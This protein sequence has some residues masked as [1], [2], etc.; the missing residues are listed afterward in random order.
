MVGAVHRH[1][2]RQPDQEAGRAGHLPDVGVPALHRAGQADRRHR[3]DPRPRAIKRYSNPLP[4][5]LILT[6]IV[7]G[8]ATTGAGRWRCVVRI[9]EAYGTIEEDD[10]LAQ[11]RGCRT[12]PRSDRR[13]PPGAAG[14]RAAGRRAADRA[15]ASRRG[16]RL[17][18]RHAGERGRVRHRDRAVRSRS[19]TRR[20]S[21]TRIGS[22]PP[23]WG[24]E[25]R[26]DALVGFVLVLVSGIGALVDALRARAA[27]PRDPGPAGLPVLRDVLPVPDR[28]A[29][30]RHHRRRCSTSSSSSRSRRSRPTC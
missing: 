6:A 19:P 10:I 21:P 14:R 24:I 9:R 12:S 5:V 28:A 27:S 20:R 23:P 1:R 13:A 29:R 22:W 11:R 30:H 8:V 17:A 25:Y 3:P 2:A 16:G 7:V 26:V 18:R 4:H 15:A